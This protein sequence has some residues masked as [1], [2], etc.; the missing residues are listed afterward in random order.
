LVFFHEKGR[1]SVLKSLWK[2]VIG[3][4]FLMGCH[5]T[6]L[7]ELQGKGAEKIKILLEQLYQIETREDLVKAEND[8]KKIFESL[9]DLMIEARILQQKEGEW[10][11]TSVSMQEELSYCLLAELKRIYALEGGRECI[12]R[13]EREAMLRLDAKEKAILRQQQFRGYAR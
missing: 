9:V 10:L 5:T 1:K 3:S 8:I 2:L 12:E 4:V 6:S 13:A 11:F 7:E